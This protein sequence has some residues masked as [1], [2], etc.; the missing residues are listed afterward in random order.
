MSAALTSTSPV[1][2]RPVVKALHRALTLCGVDR[3]LFFLALIAGAAT[4]NLF[5]SLLAGLLVTVALYTAALVAAWQDPQF[6]AI[7]L[8]SGRG[9]RR[10]DLG[11]HA[12]VNVE[13]R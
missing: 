2:V 13:L 7:L 6:L 5:Y 3:R 11:K 9:R 10:Y 1:K 12:S 4:F 8:A